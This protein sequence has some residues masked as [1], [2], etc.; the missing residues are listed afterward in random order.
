MFGPDGL[1]IDN[2]GRHR[3]PV[4]AGANLRLFAPSRIEKLPTD[5]SPRAA[6][7]TAD[8]VHDGAVDPRVVDRRIDPVSSSLRARHDDLVTRDGLTHSHTAPV[9]PMPLERVPARGGV[10]CDVDLGLEA[11]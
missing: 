7:P 8:E 11:F 6:I 5:N 2:A 4:R 1:T 9:A 10:L 3:C